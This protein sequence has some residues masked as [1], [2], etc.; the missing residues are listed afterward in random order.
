[1][2][3]KKYDYTLIVYSKDGDVIA[4]EG[5]YDS[6]NMAL[7]DSFLFEDHP[8]FGSYEIEEEERDDG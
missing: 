2:T 6:H 5:P 4:E 1:V 3:Y 8:D 7:V